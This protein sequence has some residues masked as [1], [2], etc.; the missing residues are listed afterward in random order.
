MPLTLPPTP[1]A[2]AI[3]ATVEGLQL[4]VASLDQAVAV[5]QQQAAEN[6]AFVSALE[7]QSSQ[8]RAIANDATTVAT[9]VR[10]VL[11]EFFPNAGGV[12]IPGEVSSS[13]D[14]P[15]VSA[16]PR[17]LF[18][19]RPFVPLS[20]RPALQPIFANLL[21]ALEA[22]TARVVDLSTKV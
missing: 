11:A 16:A 13:P 4:L 19:Q 6:D 1:G 14:M 7:E 9:H 8:L 12:V 10:G 5:N 3:L 21:K 18:G 15:N 22:L 17:A 2:D 20:Q